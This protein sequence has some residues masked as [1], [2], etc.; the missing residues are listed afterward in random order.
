MRTRGTALN[1]NN[2]FQPIV[3]DRQVDDGWY[4]NSDDDVCPDTMA[5]EVMDEQV[6]SII[7]RNQSP[8]VP[9]DQSINPYRGCEHVMLGS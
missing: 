9:F 7:S 5:T 1:P 8:D 3:T 4:Q 2:R 6:K